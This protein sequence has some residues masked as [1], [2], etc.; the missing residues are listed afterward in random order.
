MHSKCEKKIRREQIKT[1]NRCEKTLNTLKPHS[2]SRKHH[3][4]NKLSHENDG[5]ARG[6]WQPA[7]R[8]QLGFSPH[9]NHDTLPRGDHAL[10]RG[11]AH[12]AHQRPA[13]GWRLNV[14]A[15]DRPGAT[16]NGNDDCLSLHGATPLS[17][18]GSLSH[19]SV[20]S[21]AH[22]SRSK[23]TVSGCRVNQRP[24]T[25]RP[26]GATSHDVRPSG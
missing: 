12:R 8:W 25:S 23:S 4:K 1:V 24:N 17:C 2:K 26:S 9:S 15:I 18:R 14:A 20:R 5:C 19:N 3:R 21:H 16:R 7:D 10:C 13:K 22:L 11:S 6:S